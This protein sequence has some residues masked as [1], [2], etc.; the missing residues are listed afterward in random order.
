M[1]IKANHCI[2][3]KTKLYINNENVTVEFKGSVTEVDDK[4][5]VAIINLNPVMFSEITKQ[6]TDDNK[7]SEAEE[8]VKTESEEKGKG[9]GKG[10]AK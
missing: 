6:N 3:G 9:K 10:K 2:E 5:G 1:F 7:K 8:K 4:L